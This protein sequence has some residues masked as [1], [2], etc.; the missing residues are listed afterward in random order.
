MKIRK[1]WLRQGRT[2]FKGIKELD[3]NVKKVCCL[4]K[5][6]DKWM[7]ELAFNDLG[8]V[9]GIRKRFDQKKREYEL[10]LECDEE[11]HI[12]TILKGMVKVV[13]FQDDV[14][15][16]SLNHTCSIYVTSEHLDWDSER[17][18]V[19]VRVQFT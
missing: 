17:F 10:Y 7:I 12:T 9:W 5:R 2:Y 19:P 15:A 11:G 1:V 4:P 3:I 8:D 14:S 13:A 6:P 18:D 16:W